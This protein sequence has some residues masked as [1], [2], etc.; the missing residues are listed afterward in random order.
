MCQRKKKLLHVGLDFQLLGEYSVVDRSVFLLEI[1]VNQNRKAELIKL[2]PFQTVKKR[3][4]TG[5]K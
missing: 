1:N 4:I 3:T 2:R 5:Y